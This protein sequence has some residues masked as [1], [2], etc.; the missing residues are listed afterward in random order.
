MVCELSSTEL[1]KKEGERKWHRLGENVELLY[2]DDFLNI[3]SV[4]NATGRKKQN[5]KS[6]KKYA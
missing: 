6:V 1:F 2:R 3:E 4:S 5:N